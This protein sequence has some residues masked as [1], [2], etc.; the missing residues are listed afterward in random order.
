M[1]AAILCE[2]VELITESLDALNK[3]VK[4]VLIKPGWSL[5]GRYYPREVLAKAAPLFEGVKAYA[6]HP[7]REQMQRGESRS[8]LDITG[9]YTN[10]Q[11][12]EDGA[13]TAD[14]HVFGAAGEAIWPLIVRSVETKRPTIGI[15]INAAGRLKEGEAEARKGSVVEDISKANSA[16]D[17]DAPA[18]GGEF[19]TLLMGTDSLTQDLIDA[20]NYDEFITARPDFIETIRKQL[21]RERQDEAVRAVSEERDQANAALVEARTRIQEL[22]AA[23]VA[24]RAEVE[25]QEREAALDTAVTASK[26]PESWHKD[27]RK[28][29]SENQPAEWDAIVQ[30]EQEKYSALTERQPVHVSGAPALVNS[31]VALTESPRPAE[32]EDVGSWMK[33]VKRH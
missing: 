18:A 9:D 5:N 26:L 13:L 19:T 20:M 32:H 8:V 25:R 21:K 33:R 15:S 28:R 30:I 27:L 6:N 3:T 1:S 29:L 11:V 16:D 23:Q 31:T 2:Q 12:R 22:E 24:H 4:V 17:V 7:T 10:V 14:R